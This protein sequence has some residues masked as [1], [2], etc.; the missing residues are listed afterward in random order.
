MYVKFAIAVATLVLVGGAIDNV[1]TCAV[2]ISINGVAVLNVKLSAIR[3][4]LD[5]V[6]ADFNQTST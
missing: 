2:G 4:A 1:T 3:I 5:P 6:V